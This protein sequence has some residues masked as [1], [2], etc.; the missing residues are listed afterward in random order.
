[1]AVRPLHLFAVILGS[2]EIVLFAGVIFGWH[3]IVYIYKEEGYFYTCAGQ[4]ETQPKLSHSSSN[5]TLLSGQLQTNASYMYTTADNKFNLIFTLAT[6]VN[7]LLSVVNGYLYDRFG[8][9]FC[10]IILILCYLSGLSFNIAASADRPSL[11]FPGF[12]LTTY[13]GYLILITNLQLAG[14]IPH[15]RSMLMALY[16]GSYDISA[17]M[18][19]LFKVLFENG[20]RV[21]FSFVIQGLLFCL[22]IISST[23]LLHKKHHLPWPIPPD[24][25]LE[26]NTCCRQKKNARQ[27]N[28]PDDK[29]W[30]LNVNGSMVNLSS[31]DKPTGSVAVDLPVTKGEVKKDKEKSTTHTEV[32]ED[33]KIEETFLRTGDTTPVKDFSKI[34]L[35]PLFL[36]DLMWICIQRLINWFFVGFFNPW[37]TRLA[38][39]DKSVVSHY[40]SFF[41]VV[42]FLG[43]FTAPMSGRLMDRKIKSVHKYSNPKYEKLHASI[44]SFLLNITVS[45]LLAITMMIPV[46]EVQYL[47]C[48]LHSLHRSFLYGPNSAFLANAFPAEHFGKLF[49][50]SLTVSASFGMLQY[51]LFLLIQG[52]LNND[53]LVVNILFIIL[54]MITFIHPAYIWYYLKKKHRHQT[55]TVDEMIVIEKPS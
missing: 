36:F 1:M 44:A 50:I 28:G 22:I 54:M 14:L 15:L 33:Q 8:T 51:P 12:I 35:S 5:V 2:L 19:L 31:K 3:S 47:T 41:A 4:N 30:T 46:I 34:A 29:T 24:Y 38:C 42:Q 53:P 27:E 7:G 39:G 6:A 45:V 52:P 13:G 10:R 23:F 49:G 9:R 43:I 55:S 40:T 26:L 21:N 20:L 32:E 16:S 48:I 17:G 11:L 18:F 37:I 25:V